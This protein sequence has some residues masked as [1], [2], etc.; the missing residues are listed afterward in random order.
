[1]NKMFY[2]IGLVKTNNIF[3]IIYK[4]NEMGVFYT[5]FQNILMISHNI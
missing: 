4:F 1:M 3:K 2:K 5:N